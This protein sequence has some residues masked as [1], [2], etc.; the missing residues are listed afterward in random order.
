MKGSR[1]GP[2]VLPMR[3]RGD[4]MVSRGRAEDAG[5]S[6]WC[7]SA[8]MH[9]W[10]TGIRRQEVTELRDEPTS[11]QVMLVTRNTPP[12]EWNLF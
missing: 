8:S 1:Q 7:W 3:R 5:R 6:R 11:Q 12:L 4:V 9:R 2:D 10:T